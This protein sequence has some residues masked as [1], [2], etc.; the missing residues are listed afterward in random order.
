LQAAGIPEAVLAHTYSCLRVMSATYRREFGRFGFDRGFWIWRQSSGTIFRLGALEYEYL[1]ELSESAAQKTGLTAGKPVLTIHIP[2]GTDLS[3]AALDA[4]Y[5]QAHA[6]YQEG[7]AACLGGGAPQA[8]MC[9]SW[10]LSPTLYSLLGEGSGIRRFADDFRLC[11]SEDKS[12][13]HRHFLFLA[14][15][16]TPVADFPEDTSLRRAVKAHLLAGGGIGAGMGVLK[17]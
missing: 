13:G 8:I 5:A 14:G 4:S 1:P 2:T 3:R 16:D 6:F 10:L 9:D 17:K 11:S 12:E 7:S 15:K